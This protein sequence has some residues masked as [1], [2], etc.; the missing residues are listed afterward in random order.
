MKLLGGLKDKNKRTRQE[1][2]KVED[3]TVL[4]SISLKL[5][6]GVT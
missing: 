1:Q 2:C 6:D 4:D 5:K 3:L